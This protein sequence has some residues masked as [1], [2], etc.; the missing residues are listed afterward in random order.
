MDAFL[1]IVDGAIHGRQVRGTTVAY[2]W[3]V[4]GETR[5]H[6][7]RERD[8]SVAFLCNGAIH[9]KRVRGTTVAYLWNVN[10]VGLHISLG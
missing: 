10:G 1:W 6:S 2:L 3:N 7:R 8:T 4:N 9:V 5:I